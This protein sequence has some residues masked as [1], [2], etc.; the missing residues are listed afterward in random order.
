MQPKIP[1]LK[2]LSQNFLTDS[3]WL[4]K[5]AE[6]VGAPLPGGVTVEV[7]PGLGA[8][9]RVLLSKGHQV[10]AVE[11]D[12]R[13]RP[14]LEELSAQFP[15]QLQ[16]LFADAQETDLTPQLPCKFVSNLPYHISSPLI[17][18][19]L[20]MPFESL[21]LLMQRE[22]AQRLVAPISTKQYGRLSVWVQL[23]ADIT[24]VG[25]LRAELFRPKPAVD[26]AL[27][28]ARMRGLQLSE[29][30]LKNLEHVLFLAFSQR[31]KMLRSSLASF[32]PLNR[33]PADVPPTWRAE[34]VS[35]QQY[36]QFAQAK[37]TL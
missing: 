29:S 9:T 31:R 32:L 33:W 28:H 18:R 6:T 24:Y 20:K 25:T 2:H 27:I 1:P 36:L 22:V 10:Y 23:F 16:L 37:E 4:S 12:T 17:L 3:H 15:G 7:G 8:L 35:P 30:V 21:T 19:V 13:M 11:I 26:S 14:T 5:I 34:N